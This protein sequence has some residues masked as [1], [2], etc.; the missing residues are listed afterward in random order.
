MDEYPPI[1]PDALLD[2][3]M[4]KSG[5]QCSDQRIKRVLGLVAQKFVSD[6]ATDAHEYYKMRQQT[7]SAKEKKQQQG[8]A[9]GSVL[10]MQDL[11]AALNDYGID[12]RKPLY[13]A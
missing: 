5:M 11:S 7:L 6:V 13:Y 2:H 4:E 12:A 10:T 9:K 3:Y 1:L 8:K